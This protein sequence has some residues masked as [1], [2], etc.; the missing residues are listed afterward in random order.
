MAT[1]IHRSLDELGLV[2]AP[3]VTRLAIGTKSL[4]TARVGRPFLARLTASGGVR[5]ITWGLKAG[6]LPAGIRLVRDGRLLGTPRAAGRS[7][8]TLRATDARGRTVSRRF[9]IDVRIR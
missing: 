1:L 9:A 4:P 5:P 2:A 7:V 8:A 6:A 3:A